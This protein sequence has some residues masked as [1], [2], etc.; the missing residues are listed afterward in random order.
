M[1]GRHLTILIILISLI[2]TFSFS[3]S[4][5]ADDLIHGVV[6]TKVTAHIIG[7]SVPPGESVD[8]YMEF[9]NVGKLGGEQYSKATMTETITTAENKTTKYTSEGYFTGGPNG[10]FYL[11]L[12]MEGG[13]ATR[14]FGIIDGKEINPGYII[15]IDNPEAFDGW[16]EQE[17]AGT[18][19]TIELLVSEPAVLEGGELKWTVQAVITGD[20][21]PTVEF[22]CNPSEGMSTTENENYVI[23]TVP[24]GKIYELTAT[25]ENWNLKGPATAV[26]AFVNEDAGARFSDISG[27]VQSLIWYLW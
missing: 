18:A 4:I 10:I 3:N 20:P 12:V 1:K 2:L 8:A 25:A 14:Q 15:P 9:W 6:P 23:I 11:T 26:M 19:P 7:C 21:E 24:E 17:L 22:S 27:R 13:T 5:F 16:M